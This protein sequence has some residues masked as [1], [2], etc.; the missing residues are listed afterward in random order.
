M[1]RGGGGLPTVIVISTLEVP[2]LLVESVHTTVRM[3]EEGMAPLS[4][5]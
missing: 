1:V 5:L 3:T 4:M 2:V